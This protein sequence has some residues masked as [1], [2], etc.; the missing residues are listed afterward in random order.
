MV[1]AAACASS[2]GGATQTPTAGGTPTTA[3]ATAASGSPVAGTPTPDASALAPAATGSPVASPGP[4]DYPPLN[5]DITPSVPLSAALSHADTAWAG[6]LT[7]FPSTDGT[8]TI[9]VPKNWHAEQREGQDFLALAY[10]DE[11]DLFADVHVQC[12]HGAT[13]EGLI[14]QDRTGIFA[15]QLA[16]RVQLPQTTTIAGRA[17]QEVRWSGGFNDLITDNVSFYIAIA[18]CVWRLQFGVYDGLRI[19]DYRT[20]IEAIVASFQSK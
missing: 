3:G 5:P 16:Y 12:V 9:S 15:L 14:E 6:P 2:G 17:F 19:R 1:F 20:D 11:T 4:D 13:A 10:R 18:D 7:P 8:F